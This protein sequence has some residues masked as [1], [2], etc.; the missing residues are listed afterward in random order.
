MKCG[1]CGQEVHRPC[2]L[3]LLKSMNLLNENEEMAVTFYRIPEMYYLCASCQNTTI[4]FLYT[5]QNT[6]IKSSIID[7]PPTENE[8]SVETKPKVGPLMDPVT[9]SLTDDSLRMANILQEQ[10]K[11]VFTTPNTQY[12]HPE[13]EDSQIPEQL[14]DI[15]LTEEDFAREI[16][17]LDNNSAAGPDGFP[18]ILLKKSTSQLAKPLKLIWRNI[19]DKGCTPKILKTS[20]ITPVFKKG[21]Q[22]L[23]ENYQPVALTSHV[24]KVFEKIFRKKLQDHLED[25]QLYNI[26][27]HGFRSGRSCL[28]QLLS[29]TEQLIHY[30][31]EGHNV[32]VIYLDFS[33]AFDRVDHSILLRKIRKKGISGKLHTWIKSFLTGRSQRVSVNTK[34]SED[35][36]VISGVPQGSVLGPLLFL[37]MIHDIDEEVYHSVLSSF[38][39]DTRL[40]KDIS[41]ISDV[42]RLQND[43]DAVYKWTES[44]NMAL[45]GLKFEHIKY[46][47]NQ[48][49]KEHS[50]Y[51]SDTNNQ[52]EAKSQVKDLGV[53]MDNNMNYAQHI[54]GQIEKVKG[55]SAWIYRTF[56]TRDA[57]VMLTIWKS[58]A[59]PHL[60]YCSQLWSP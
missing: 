18:A 21:N 42:Q 38:A 46:G 19:L 45:N 33:K 6:E 25:N 5:T 44:N 56:R 4:N 41:N 2:Y 9:K 30:I 55:I 28:S 40:M 54:Q 37:I 57:H 51:L 48:N 47:K 12:N 7:S 17:T 27:Q 24:T 22:G 49:Q 52:I 31:E 3:K 13:L 26:N 29:H 59:I 15:E 43:L 16:S 35:A 23:P 60:D 11:S 20:Y 10:Y 8:S 53:V 1:S 32:D 58:L 50:T 39:D 34:L 14:D 36:E